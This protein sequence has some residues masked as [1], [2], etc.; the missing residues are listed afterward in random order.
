MV[1]HQVQKK[2]HSE[3]WDLFALVQGTKEKS[4][5]RTEYSWPVCPL[6]PEFV[7]LCFLGSP[8]TQMDLSQ[9]LLLVPLHLQSG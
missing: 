9:V 4:Y 2:K 6:K 3:V 7:L 5:W 1:W 8:P